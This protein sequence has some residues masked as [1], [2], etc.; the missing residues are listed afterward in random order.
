MRELRK[1]CSPAIARRA[2]A[3][4][5]LQV[6]FWD[7]HP[8]RLSIGWVWNYT[9]PGQSKRVPGKTPG[10]VRGMDTVGD[11]SFESAN[12]YIRKFTLVGHWGYHAGTG[13]KLPAPSSQRGVSSGP[14]PHNPVVRVREELTHHPS[15]R[16]K[17]GKRRQ[18]RGACVQS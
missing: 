2:V 6:H 3:F 4:R 14:S 18:G 7:T 12:H 9:V 17:S 1:C 15:P 13:R 11:R 10:H 8:S 16:A 5:K